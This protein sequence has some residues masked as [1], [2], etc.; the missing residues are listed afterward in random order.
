MVCRTAEERAEIRERVKAY[1]TER[2][3]REGVTGSGSG[4]TETP[5]TLAAANPDGEDTVAPSENLAQDGV[6]N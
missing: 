6:D 5:A 4:D 1:I 2:N 3:A